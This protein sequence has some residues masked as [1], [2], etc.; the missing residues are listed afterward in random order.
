MTNNNK[1]DKQLG[2]PYGTASSRLKKIIMFDLVKQLKKDICYHCNKKI[3]TI[4]EFS[5]EHKKPW[6]DNNSDLFWDLDNISFSHLSCNSA[7]TRNTM[8]GKQTPHGTSNRYDYHKCRCAKC[9]EANTKRRQQY[10]L[11]KKKKKN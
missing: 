3:E 7:N 11:R 4:R 10:R 9:C 5:I 1:K 2:M 6:L 8:K